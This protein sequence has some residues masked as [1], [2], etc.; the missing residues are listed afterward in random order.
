MSEM[1]YGKKKKHCMLFGHND[2][3]YSSKSDKEALK[4]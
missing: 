4:T 3:T 1:S 2:N